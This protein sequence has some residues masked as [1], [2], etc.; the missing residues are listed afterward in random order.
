MLYTGFLSLAVASR[1]CPS[2]QRTGFSCC[3]A[4]ALSRLLSLQRGRL[5]LLQS[6]GS[7]TLQQLQHVGSVVTAHGL[8][9]SAAYVTLIPEPRVEPMSHALASRFLTTGLIR[10]SLYVF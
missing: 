9:R 1:S 3:R 2:L 8:S 10:K 6:A 7:S 5:L 4:Q